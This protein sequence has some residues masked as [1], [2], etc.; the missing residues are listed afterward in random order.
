MGIL[1]GKIKIAIQFQFASGGPAGG[2][3][4]K[5]FDKQVL[6]TSLQ[7]S[8]KEIHHVFWNV[9]VRGFFQKSDP[10]EAS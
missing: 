3:T 6:R 2:Q 10:P 1:S 5:K 7:A 8:P 4:F 9:F